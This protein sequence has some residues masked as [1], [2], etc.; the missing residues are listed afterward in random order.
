M[1]ARKRTAAMAAIAFGL[2]ACEGGAPPGPGA[3]S[4]GA[5]ASPDAQP[6][7]SNKAG[8]AQL[9]QL[10]GEEIRAA[11]TGNLVSYSKPGWADT[12]VHEEFHDGGRWRGIRYSRGP[13][14]FSGRWHIEN[15]QLCVTAETGVVA[16]ILRDGPLCRAVWRDEAIDGL[17]MEDAMAQGGAP[18]PLRVQSL[19]EFPSSDR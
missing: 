8:S 14:P 5:H 19:A 16:G 15:S 13:I 3:A 18:L 11:L 2:A 1:S 9:R 17:L 6:A 12:G 10:D 4:N 7:V